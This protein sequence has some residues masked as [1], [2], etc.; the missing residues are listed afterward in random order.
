MHNQTMHTRASHAGRGAKPGA[1]S[2][3]PRKISD[4]KRVLRG[5]FQTIEAKRREA[6]ISVSRLCRAADINN[7]TYAALTHEPTRI[8]NFRTVTRL[9]RALQHM[10]ERV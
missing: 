4:E 9:E 7:S 1:K 5:R 10:S 3:R 6:G 2:G 8:P